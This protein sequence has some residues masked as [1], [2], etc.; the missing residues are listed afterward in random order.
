[1]CVCAQS[2]SHVQLFATPW[3]VVCRIL[4]MEFSRQEYQNRL[5]FPT[6]GD[7]PNPGVESTSLVSPALAG[8]FFTTA[9]PGKLMF[10]I[11]NYQGNANQNHNVI[12]FT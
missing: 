5:P 1:M 9:L 3:T 6:P 2:F 4:S 8:I 12:P 11:N 10:N 7:L